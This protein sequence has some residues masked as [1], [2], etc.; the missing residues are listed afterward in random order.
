MTLLWSPKALRR[1]TPWVKFFWAKGS[2]KR[3]LKCERCGVDEW[4]NLGDASPENRFARVHS[5]C[6]LEQGKR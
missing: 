4:I 6:L 3:R 2:T 5:K 1:K